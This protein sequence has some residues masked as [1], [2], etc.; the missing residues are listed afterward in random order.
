MCKPWNVIPWS[1]SGNTYDAKEKHEK[2]ELKM[3]EAHKQ[4]HNET[5]KYEST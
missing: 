5:W 4:G 3:K 1:E 2:E